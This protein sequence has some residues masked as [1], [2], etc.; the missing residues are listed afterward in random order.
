MKR[1]E[2]VVLVMSMV[3]FS[4]AAWGNAPLSMQI[5]HDKRNGD[6]LIIKAV[7]ND[8]K[9]NA[10]NVNDG[11]CAELYFEG[12]KAVVG[13]A[14]PK[15]PVMNYG[16]ERRV[17]LV[18]DTPI[19]NPCRVY[20]VELQT[21]QGNYVYTADDY[22]DQHAQAASIAPA[23]DDEPH[24]P[25]TYNDAAAAATE[26][27]TDAFT[28]KFTSEGLDV[29]AD[30]DVVINGVI[31]ASPT[32]SVASSNK[33]GLNVAA[34]KT[35]HYKLVDE[36]GQTCSVPAVSVITNYGMFDYSNE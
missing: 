29:I 14:S 35:V 20:K 30:K 4:F 26:R 6:D 17:S 1:F 27:P 25:S 24:P 33:P 7:A 21:N 9:V 10:V 22:V 34:G 5:E 12:M 16:D 8:V 36:K 11:K 23:N 3:V 13:D 31:P 32:C 19:V 28:V 2:N 15:R 18:L